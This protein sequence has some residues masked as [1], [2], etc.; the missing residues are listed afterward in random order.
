MLDD[1]LAVVD[2]E[3]PCALVPPYHLVGW[4]IVNY[5]TQVAQ[6]C[7]PLFQV[8]KLLARDLT[9]VLVVVFQSTALMTIIDVSRGGQ[10]PTPAAP[11]KG[12]RENET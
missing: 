11:S 6:L 7:E 10:V 1:N 2:I 3:Y 8:A 9:R 4:Q 12:R 5:A